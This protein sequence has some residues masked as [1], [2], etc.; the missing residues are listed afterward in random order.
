MP[1]PRLHLMRI[2]QRHLQSSFDHIKHRLPIR[3]RAL[4]DGVA[5]TVLVLS[6]HG[7]VSTLLPSCRT[8][9]LRT[10]LP[11]RQVQSSCRPAGRSFLHR[12]RCTAQSPLESCSWFSFPHP[13]RERRLL[14]RSSSTGLRANRG[15]LHATPAGF[16]YE[17]PSV[18][19]SAVLPV[20]SYSAHFPTR[21]WPKIDHT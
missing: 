2:H 5:C 16:V 9:A 20:L 6:I 21:G 14:S 15:S 18:P 17:L 12:Y 11:H 13:K 1:L 7:V 8:G 19:S 3:A 10:A 4:H